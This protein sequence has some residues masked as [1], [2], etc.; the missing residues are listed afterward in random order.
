[1]LKVFVISPEF[2][3]IPAIKGG[4]VETLL[5][6]LIEE[7]E[8][9]KEIELTV[10]SPREGIEK[11]EKQEYNTTR[12]IYMK[13]RGFL[14]KIYEF[15][16]CRLEYHFNI[17]MPFCKIYYGKAFFHA[18]FVKPDLIVAEGIGCENVRLF[19]KTFGTEK[20][21]LHLHHEKKSDENNKRVY[22]NVIAVSEYIKTSWLKGES[23]SPDHV[24]V[25]RNGIDEK[26]F[27]KEF[28]KEEWKKIRSDLGCSEEDFIVLFCGR[29]VPVKGVK[30]LV[31]AW[32]IIKDEYIKLLI[33]GGTNFADSENTLYLSEVQEL[34]DKHRDRMQMMGYLQNKELYKYYN[35]AD[36]QVIPSLWE[37][38]AGLVGIEGM[39]CGCPLIITK[40]GGMVEYISKKCSIQ[41]DK[42]SEMVTELANAI[43]K[44]KND[45]EKRHEMQILALEC[46]KEYTK[47]NY[48]KDFMKCLDK[49]REK[50]EHEMLE[51]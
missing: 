45:K 16:C 17:H 3:P 36:L 22:G 5:T 38:P 34:V 19:A 15:I 37:E 42:G 6:Y 25:V 47:E 40:S 51:K 1:M 30:E 48:Y 43:V 35:I 32:N 28:T 13:S 26:R 18:L 21:I 31:S 46:A 9:K 14:H 11:A 10:V 2:L 44:M 24:F 23:I 12:I 33:V 50:N 49:I 29:I 8:K 20:M 27:Q 7:N 39:M 4:A 41:I